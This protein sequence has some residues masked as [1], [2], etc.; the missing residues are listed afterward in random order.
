[1]DLIIQL[2]K[3]KFILPKI[4]FIIIWRNKVLEGQSN[5]ILS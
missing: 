1:M 5:K 4:E 2:G 3:D